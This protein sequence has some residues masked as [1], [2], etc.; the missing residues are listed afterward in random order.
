M[1]AN[2]ILYVQGID[3]ILYE[4]DNEKYISLTDIARHKMFQR[5]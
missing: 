1:T 5:A 3:V 4:M 2:K